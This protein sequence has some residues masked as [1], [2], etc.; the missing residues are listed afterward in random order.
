MGVLPLL[1]LTEVS[2]VALGMAYGVA[3]KFESAD[4]PG[5]VIDGGGLR[6]FRYERE[7]LSERHFDSWDWFASF[8]F[9]PVVKWVGAGVVSFGSEPKEFLGSSGPDNVCRIDVA[10]PHVFLIL[11]I[12]VVVPEFLK[13][14]GFGFLGSFPFFRGKGTEVR[15]A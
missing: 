15:E 12:V 9:A 13:L 10:V 11:F 5:S 6:T 2:V 1:L 7:F 4:E 8:G 14:T 3:K